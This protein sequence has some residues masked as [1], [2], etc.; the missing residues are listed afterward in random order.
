MQLTSFPIKIILKLAPMNFLSTSTRALGLLTNIRAF[1]ISFRIKVSCL[2]GSCA[3]FI[4]MISASAFLAVARVWSPHA[5][6]SA[7]PSIS[8]GASTI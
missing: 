6:P 8:A 4:I 3:R 2:T 5:L 7:E 1:S